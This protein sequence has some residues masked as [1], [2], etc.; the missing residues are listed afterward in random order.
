MNSCVKVFFYTSSHE[1]KTVVR[2][3]LCIT[4]FEATRGTR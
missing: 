2:K 1:L 4:E 3:F